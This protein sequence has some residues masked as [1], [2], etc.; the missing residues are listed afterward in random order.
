MSQLIENQINMEYERQ[1]L[2]MERNRRME[3][4]MKYQ[5]HQQQQQ[6]TIFRNVNRQEIH[7]KP[8]D[9]SCLGQ[10]IA[11]IL[12]FGV[13]AVIFGQVFSSDSTPEI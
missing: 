4:E 7:E 8:M 2:Q 5:S 3:N 6:E 13:I 9:C 1:N 10:V 12:I 11:Y